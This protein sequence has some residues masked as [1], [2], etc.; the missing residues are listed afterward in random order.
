MEPYGQDIDPG[1]GA[2][3]IS[4]RDNEIEEIVEE[5]L[6]QVPQAT[7]MNNHMGSKFTS[8][9]DNVSEALKIIKQ[10]DLFFVDSLTSRH[11]QAYKMARRLNMRTAP[12]NVF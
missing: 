3:Y 6:S 10:R 5:N 11:S 2:L 8:C 4:F 7:G 1:P 12:R 9:P